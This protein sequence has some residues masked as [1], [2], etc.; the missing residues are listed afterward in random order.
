MSAREIRERGTQDHGRGRREVRVEFSSL[1][2]MPNLDTSEMPVSPATETGSQDRTARDDV[3]SQAM[4]RILERVAGPNSGSGGQGSVT[5]RLRSNRV[6]LFRGVTGVAPNKLKGTV[7]LL[8]DKACQ[9]WLTI[10]EGTQPNR[11]TWGFFKTAFQSKYVGASYVDAHKP[12]MLERECKFSILVKKAKIAEDVKRAERQNKDRERGKNKRD[13]EPSSSVQRPKKKAR[14]DGPVRVGAP[15]ASTGML[16][17]GDCG[18]CHPGECW[19]RIGAC[20][21][22]REQFYSHIGALDRLGVVTVWVVDREYRAKVLDRLSTASEVIVLSLLGHSVLVSKLYRDVPLMVQGAI[23]LANL[24]ELPF[25]EFNLILDYLSNVISALVA[26]KLVRKGCEA[27]L[28]YVEFGIELLPSTASVSIAPYRMAPKE[29][30]ELKAQLQELLDRDFIR[31]SVSL[32]GAPVLFAKKKDGTMRMCIY[33]RQLNKLTVK[34]KYLLPRIDDLFDQFRGTSVFSKIDLRSRYHQL[35]VKEADV[36]K[37]EF[38]THY[39]HCEFVMVFINDILVY[40]K[41]KD[42]HDRHI[43]VVLQI[44]REKQL[45]TKLKCE[46]WLREVTFLGHIVSIKGIRVNPRK[47]EAVLDWKQLKNVSE[48]RNFLGLTGYCRR[49]IEGFF[50]IAVSLTKLLHKGPESGKEFVVYSDASHVGLGCVLVQDGKVVAYAS[51]QL[52]TYEVNYLTHDVK[53]AVVVVEL[54]I[55]RHY[56][57]SERCIIYINHKSLRYLF[58]QKELNLRQRRWIELLKD[59]DCT[60]EYHPDKANVVADALSRRAMSDLWVMFVRLSLFDDGR[61]LA[62]LQVKPTCINQMDKQLG[63]ESLGLRFRQIES[64]T[65]F[66]FG[67]NSDGVLRFR[68]QIYVPKN[69]DLRQSIL[70]E[71]HSSPYVMHPGGNKMYRDLHELY[72]LYG[73]IMV[74]RRS[75]GNLRTR[76]VSSILIC[77]DQWLSVLGVGERS[78]VQAL[79]LWNLNS[80]E[81]SVSGGRLQIVSVASIVWTEAFRQWFQKARDYFSIGSISGVYRNAEKQGLAKA[82]KLHYRCHTGLGGCFKPHMVCRDGWRWY[83]ADL[84]GSVQ[85]R[86]QR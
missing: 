49:F 3:L 45:Y 76:F 68:G 21:S 71:G 13:L 39:G 54:K 15:V 66:E 63:D 78:Q 30:T 59:Y 37:T 24:M 83:S 11:L 7:S 52:K 57:Y 62:E 32:W 85:R 35:R 42:E 4:L 65:I 22:L 81:L 77:S 46:F 20:L 51:R 28:A 67:L 6:E 75:R 14:S 16:P 5:E 80:E 84:G 64:G 9:W 18:R 2:S 27:Y 60:I 74:L 53:L 12:A 41:T 58:T 38:R 10:K 72:W 33:Y 79:T 73:G 70:M 26:E 34:N 43:R 44:L 23:F 48:I 29:L 25:G 8:R 40:S 47:I 50:L 36:H 55:W 31:P 56:L 61:L 17:C 69:S 86:T 19:K 1:G 82:E